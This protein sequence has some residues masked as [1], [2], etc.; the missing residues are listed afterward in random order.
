[1]RGSNNCLH[2]HHV[3]FPV[4]PETC[5][6]LTVVDQTR[7]GSCQKV[8]NGYIVGDRQNPPRLSPHG[9]METYH[10]ACHC[11]SH[12]LRYTVPA[13]EAFTDNGVCDCSHC[14]KRRAVWI[15][16]PSGALEVVRGV[17]GTGEGGK[18]LSGYSFGA[19]QSVHQVSDPSPVAAP[20]YVLR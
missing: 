8:A 13:D 15:L 6:L 5:G 4:S 1:M 12:V 20:C 3:A 11:Q 14:L 10:V 9:T 7:A 17:N 2:F 16:A 19:K 18:K